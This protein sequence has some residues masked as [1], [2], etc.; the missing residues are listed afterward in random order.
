MDIERPTKM[1]LQASVAPFNVMAK[2][3]GPACNLD[4]K[5]CFYL[6]KEALFQQ[7][8]SRRMSLDTLDAYT[9]NYIQ[10][11][12]EGQPITFAWQGGEPVLRG[13]DFFKQAVALQRTYGGGRRIENTFQTNGTL[14]DDDWCKF[15]AENEFLVGLSLDGPED[16]HDHYRVSRSGEPT[17]SQVMR[18]L[19][20]LQ[21]HKVDFNV[22]ACVNRL[23]S[24]SPLK[25]YRFFRAN[26]VKFVQF[27]P[28]VERLS[29]AD[30]R[31]QG[32]TLEGP[33][34]GSA[35]PA[36]PVTE[37]SVEPV[38]W[39]RFLTTIFDEWVAKDVGSM[40]VMNFEW[41]LA[42]FM[43][44]RS[45]VVCVHQENCGRAVIAEH[46]GDIFSCDHF[47]YPDYR[48][49]NLLET[50]LT[51]ML[52]SE[53]QKEFGTAKSRTLPQ[54]CRQCRYLRGCWGDCPKHRFIS[55]KDGEP[56][57]SY[58]CEGYFHYLQHVAPSLSVL[59]DLIRSNR[60]ATEIMNMT[61]QVIGRK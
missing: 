29:S 32:F 55:T 31:S 23:S 5:Y 53:R 41:S 3:S 43:N 42:A 14:L 13:L 51:D 44:Q 10:S 16:I 18:A 1:R 22:L 9:S 26:G 28:I 27:I 8:K 61:I 60:P 34:T 15:L 35:S 57:L 49:G 37:W 4:C 2:P 36:L 58:L 11:H 33:A 17:H 7:N 20:L 30:Y 21:R 50:S 12:P 19:N 52:D 56:G 25:V 48:L 59:S 6:E 54:Q 47:A 45:G 40:F 38:R 24:A 39:G 46:N